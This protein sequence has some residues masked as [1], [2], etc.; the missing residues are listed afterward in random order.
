MSATLVTRT[1][2]RRLPPAVRRATLTVHI[3]AS[4]ALL[5]TC[6]AMVAIDVRAATTP[7]RALAA[8]AY[9]L[10]TMFS[11]LFGIPLSFTSLLSGSR[12]ASGRSGACFATAGSRPSWC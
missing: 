8:S 4:V 1:P 2:A 5:G 11:L 9:E 7:D 12:S 3:V 6:A 10:L